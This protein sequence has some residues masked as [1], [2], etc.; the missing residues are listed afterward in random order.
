MS[1]YKNFM[2]A[3]TSRHSET[4]SDRTQ[5]TTNLEGKNYDVSSSDKEG[6]PSSRASLADVPFQLI[7]EEMRRKRYVVAVTG[8][9]GATLAIRLLQALRALD[10][11]THLVLSKWAVKTLK[12]ETDMT[13]REVSQ[14]VFLTV[15]SNT[16]S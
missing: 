13:E 15:C 6:V 8:A 7:P 10:V 5:S 2:S 1:G 9:T 11:E 4:A 12:Y 3:I 14:A 16:N